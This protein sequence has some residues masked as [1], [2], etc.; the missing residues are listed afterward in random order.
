MGEGHKATVGANYASS[1]SRARVRMTPGPDVGL[2]EQPVWS[3]LRFHAWL[4]G[5]ATDGQGLRK[6][7]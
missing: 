5:V 4:E 2:W 6:K 1:N 3:Y 7:L